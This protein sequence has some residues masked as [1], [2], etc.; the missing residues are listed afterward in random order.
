MEAHK[1]TLAYQ[2]LNRTER[3]NN[4]IFTLISTLIKALKK[5]FRLIRL[6]VNFKAIHR[7]LVIK[8]VLLKVDLKANNKLALQLIQQAKS[9]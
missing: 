1:P 4:L 6:M 7:D 2:D 5:S 3:Y 9:T 8:E